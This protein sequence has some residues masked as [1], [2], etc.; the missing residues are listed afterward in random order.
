[1]HLRPK[2]LKFLEALGLDSS[3][4]LV[5]LSA[6]ESSLML[7]V[8]VRDHTHGPFYEMLGQTHV[9]GWSCVIASQNGGSTSYIFLFRLKVL[10]WSRHLFDY[11]NK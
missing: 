2:F 11:W 8:L 7:L 6:S 10:Q 3:R 9:N 4:A 5:N 1:M